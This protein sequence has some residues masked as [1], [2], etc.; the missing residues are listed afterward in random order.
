ML[1][2]PLLSLEDRTES[3]EGSIDPLGTYA[4][5]DALGVRLIPGVRERQQHIRFL[6]AMAVSLL[7]CSEFEE[8]EVAADGVSE[9]WQVFEWYFVEGMVRKTKQSDDLRGLPGRDKATI[10]QRIG[11]PLSAKRYL[12]TPRVFGFHGVYRGLARHV[13]VDQADRLGELGYRLLKVWE[14]E[15]GLTGFCGT[16]PGE[17]RVMRRRLVEAVRDGLTKGHVARPHS[18]PHYQFFP[19]TLAIRN[20][21]REEAALL[22]AALLDDGTGFRRQVCSFLVT[23]EARNSWADV[24]EN[25]R[26]E[27]SFHR[28]LAKSADAELKKLLD[29]IEVYERFSRLLQDAFDDTLERASSTKTRVRPK[30]LTELKSVRRA[31]AD[32]APLVPEIVDRLVDFQLSNDFRDEFRLFEDKVEPIEFAQRLLK[33]H[34]QVQRSKPPDGKAPWFDCFDDGSFLIRTPYLRK[35]G[36]QNDDSYVHAYRTHSLWSFARDLKLVN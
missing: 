16:E 2:G 20:A 33:H 26:S 14:K 29:T 34:C 3:A 5:A 35:V 23:K 7:V 8:D 1:T 21:G 19:D 13:G 15:Q 24:S 10:A 30:D 28:A 11:E 32:V 27:R 18:W 6:T 31:A 9:P 22:Q 17:G 36:G 4:I 12:K 25:D